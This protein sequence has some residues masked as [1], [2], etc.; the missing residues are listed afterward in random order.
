MD[1]HILRVFVSSPGD[2]EVERRLAQGVLKRLA[3]RYSRLVKLEPIFWEHEP[4]VATQSFQ[5]GIPSPAE[6]DIVVCILWARIGTRLP[7]SIHRPD[8]SPYASGTEFEF[9]T[10]AAAHRARGQPDLLVYR[11]TALPEFHGEAPEK[12]HEFADQW[13][14]LDAFVQKW[15][16]GADGTLTAAFSPFADPA[17]FEEILEIHL[18]RLIEGRLAGW[19]ISAEALSQPPPR[20][21]TRGSP[22]RGLE[23]FEFEHA[24]IFF[25]RTRAVG[26]VLAALRRQAQEGRAFL[27]VLGSSGCGKSSLVQAGVLPMLTGPGVIEGVGLWRRAILR[28]AALWATGAAAASASS[29]EKPPESVLAEAAAGQSGAPSGDLFDAL[30]A[31]LVEPAALPEL[32]ADG[33][34]AVRLAE[35]LRKSPTGAYGLVKGALSQAAASLR[36]AEGVKV[37]PEARLV[38]VVDQLEE[39][40]TDRHITAEGRDALFVALADLAR[41]GKVWVIATL[42]SD[43]YHRCREIPGLAELKAENGQLDLAPITTAEIGRMI[44]QPAAAAGLQFEVDPQTGQPLDDILLNDATALEEGLP[45]LE[46]A[47][48]ELYHRA[49]PNGA[50]VA[51]TDGASSAQSAA[52]AAPTVLKLADYRAL[53]GLAGCLAERAEQTFLELDAEAREAFA[54]VL[55]KLVVLGSGEK[56]PTRRIAP[57]SEF[58]VDPAMSRFVERFVAA[59]LFTADRT[60]GSATVRIAHE[61]LL[62]TAAPTQSHN[63]KPL[64]PSP[65]D[66]APQVTAQWPRLRD[67]LAADRENLQVHGRVAA[68]A[69]LWNRAGRTSDLLLQPGKPLDEGRQLLA[70]KF[71]LGNVETQ[72]IAA[73][74]RQ[75]LRRSRLK[76]AAVAALIVLS[77]ATAAA[78]VV[79]NHLRVAATESQHQESVAKDEAVQAKNVALKAEKDAVASKNDADKARNDAEESSTKAV[80]QLILSY[81]DRGTNELTHGDK[82]RGLAILGQAYRAAKN[83]SKLR[84]SVRALLGSWYG[85]G[86]RRLNHDDAVMAVAISPEGTKVLTASGHRAQLWD[87]VTDNPVGKPL[88]H[89]GTVRALAFSPDGS[90]ALT[91][92]MDFKARLWDTATGNLIGDPLQSDGAVVAVAFSPDG[93]TLLTGSDDKMARLW[94]VATGEILGKPLLHKDKVNAVSFSPDGTKAL[95]GSDDRTAR[96]W[97]AATGEPLGDP[98]PHDGQVE[99]VAF[100]PDGTKVLTG[101]YDSKAR[102]WTTATGKPF[103]APL[104]HGGPVMAVAFSPDGSKVLTGSEDKTARLWIVDTGEPLGAPLG[105]DGEV[106][107]VAFSPDGTKVLTG[108]ADKT[109][110][111]WEAATGQ[112]LGEPMLHDDQV[113]AVAFGADGSKVLTGSW[114]KT[115]RLWDLAGQPLGEPLR[116][117]GLAHT[118]LFSTDSTK[119]GWI[120][121]VAFNT[122]GTKVLTGSWDYTARIW[123]AATGK[124]LG[125]PLPNPGPVRAVAFS[126]DGTKVLTGSGIGILQPLSGGEARLWD[127]ATCKPICD[128]L[129]L[130]GGVHALAFSP[131]GS[132]A[133]TGS[134]NDFPKKGEGRLWNATAGNPLAKPLEHNGAVHAVAFS[135]DGTKVLTGSDDTT[136]RLW[137]AAMGNPIGGPLQHSDAV[138]AVAFSPDGTKMLTGSDD[139]TARLWVTA[140]GR[141]IGQP[142][143]HDNWVRSLAF[144][145]DGTK[146]IT[147]SVDDTA[148]LWDAVTGKPIG[149]PLRNNDAVNAVAFSPDG[150]KVL[151]GCGDSTRSGEGRLWD[152]TTGKPL[153]EPLRHRGSVEAVAFSPDGTTALTGSYDSTARLW[154]IPSALPEDPNLITCL[155]I[156]ASGFHEDSAGV[157][158]P[159]TREQQLAQWRE[160][161]EI[162]SQW[163]KKRSQEKLRVTLLWHKIQASD[164]EGQELWFAAAV[165]LG[166]LI[167]HDP[168]DPELRRRRARAYTQ[169]RQLD[170]A[171]ADEAEAAKLPPA[172]P[173]H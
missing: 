55:R 101:S 22:F 118:L 161:N 124:S 72:L 111:L 173:G 99:A 75:A 136:A 74:E 70:A 9:E 168:A 133:L 37:Q 108:S 110:R 164:D 104:R 5:E 36:A 109:A 137:D 40:F 54:K 8:G 77:L 86:C 107:S 83:N 132:K 144:N 79:A 59:R 4:L 92:S 97:D 141:P 169:L 152:V 33:T 53:K 65:Q 38:L 16:H 122:D 113:A 29:T 115:A 20:S 61:A 140:T 63:A 127:A 166:Y 56:V 95:T 11:K 150:T 138:R 15:F 162:G 100:S 159:T 90:K 117:S 19:G 67:W 6:S 96:L 87:A 149:E 80:H 7:P 42:R 24:P 48:D 165:H 119:V 120:Q 170:K 69:E 51:E 128:P 43:F 23:V 126:P 94:V 146:V 71:E 123:D 18:R 58:S 105:H 91:G 158:W 142:L 134:G 156:L 60:D 21:W 130:V 160:L 84:A 106:R 49:A 148:R 76:R 112:A 39:I 114:D 66:D 163:L 129:R 88:W 52:V 50:A 145:P 30:A 62:A 121:A 154:R 78:A 32:T 81:I 103:G 125:E 46:F 26:E 3:E 68:A 172:K 34:S 167:A 151:T 155:L 31:A 35:L 98:L 147:G 27:L 13:K 139:H 10:A 28:P 102:L 45:L 41:S 64:A 131:D 82:Q 47:L 143:R 57:R 85:S 116:H 17:G 12:L 93:K 73:S 2:V 14:A 1:H 25:G 44:R 171:T 89:D 157:L 135:P 153:G